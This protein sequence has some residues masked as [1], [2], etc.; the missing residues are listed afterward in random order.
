MW[1]KIR[2]LHANFIFF[3]H[4]VIQIQIILSLA[5]SEFIWIPKQKNYDVCSFIGASPYAFHPTCARTWDDLQVCYE[6]MTVDGWCV[7]RNAF[8]GMKC[9]NFQ[10]IYM[11][12]DKHVAKSFVQDILPQ[13]YDVKN[14][15]QNTGKILN[16]FTEGGKKKKKKKKKR[17]KFSL[18]RS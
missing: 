18:D 6:W 1:T 10:Y 7:V 3:F 12:H 15:I 4:P 9:M 5:N 14:T 16:S 17:V 13:L 11:C 8:C 2:G